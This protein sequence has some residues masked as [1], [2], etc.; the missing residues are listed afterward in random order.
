M[1]SSRIAIVL[2]TVALTCQSVRAQ[3]EAEQLRATEQERLRSLVEVDMDT[4]RRL[5]ADDFQLVNPSGATLT[6]DQYLGQIES[7]E[8]DYV[9]WEP[10]PI[11]VRRFAD[12]AVLR[13]QARAQAVVAGQRTPLRSFWHTDVYERRNGRWQVVWSQATLIQ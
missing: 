7:G 5:H 12:A 2:I 6:K 13:Y 10:G 8:L 11:A 9:L 1:R 4:A 3:D